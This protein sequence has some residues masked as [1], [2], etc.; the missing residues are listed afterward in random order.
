[1]LNIFPL[2]ASK[3]VDGDRLSPA[4]LLVCLPLRHSTFSG[5]ILKYVH[6]VDSSSQIIKSH[7]YLMNIFPLTA[8]EAVDGYFIDYDTELPS[9]VCL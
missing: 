3:A 1:M 2:T 8:T 5:I 7:T 4:G 9:F 6:I